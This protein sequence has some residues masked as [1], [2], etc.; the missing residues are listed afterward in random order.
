[1]ALHLA[2]PWFSLILRICIDFR[3]SKFNTFSGLFSVEASFTINT[4]NSYD[5]FDIAELI[6]SKSLKTDCQSL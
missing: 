5:R 1:M 2:C 3:L 4:E 6:L